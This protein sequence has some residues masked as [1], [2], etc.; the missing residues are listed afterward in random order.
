M[1]NQLSASR[2]PYKVELHIASFLTI[3]PFSSAGVTGL[4]LA[5]TLPTSNSRKQSF[6]KH[7]L[8]LQ[9][10]AAIVIDHQILYGYWRASASHHVPILYEIQTLWFCTTCFIFRSHLELCSVWKERRSQF[11]ST[12]LILR[13]MVLKLSQH[14]FLQN[15]I[16]W[17]K[18]HSNWCHSCQT[19]CNVRKSLYSSLQQQKESTGHACIWHL[20]F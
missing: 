14:Y 11:C 17:L 13:L 8:L 2:Q 1:L 12:L 10:W 18:P 3:V 7:S 9:T 6:F 15:E 4:L 19:H 16:D 20:L 5:R